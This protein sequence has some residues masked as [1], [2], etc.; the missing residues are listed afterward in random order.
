MRA[1]GPIKAQGFWQATVVHNY[2]RHFLGF[3]DTAAEAGEAARLKR[4][5]LYTHNALDRE[6]GAGGVT[7]VPRER[8]GHPISRGGTCKKFKGCCVHH[9]GLNQLRG[10]SET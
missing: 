8:C 1:S 4:L 6:P 5:E 10:S 2:E 3:F 9:D 7:L